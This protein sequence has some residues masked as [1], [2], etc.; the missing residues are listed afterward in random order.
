M[1]DRSS[2]VSN[3]LAKTPWAPAAVHAARNAG[4]KHF[5]WSTL[6]DVE[7]ISGGKFHVPHFTGKAR[8]DSIVKAVEKYRASLM[9]RLDLSSTAAVA[10]FA[11][12]CNLLSRQEVDGLVSAD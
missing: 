10:R 7:A 4:V 9:R 11:V 2:A 12:R 5:I 1:S 8:I 3:G 6:P